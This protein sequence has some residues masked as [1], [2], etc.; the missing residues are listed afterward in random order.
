M[1]ADPP[2]DALTAFPLLLKNF[3]VLK[4]SHYKKDYNN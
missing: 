1:I 2:F 4:C 3:T